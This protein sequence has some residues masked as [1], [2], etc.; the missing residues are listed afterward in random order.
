MIRETSSPRFKVLYEV[1]SEIKSGKDRKD[2]LREVIKIVREELTNLAGLEQDE[3]IFLDETSKDGWKVLKSSILDYQK[4]L[5][6]IETYIKSNDFKKIDEGLN[7]ASKADASLLEIYLEMNKAYQQMKE[8]LESKEKVICLKCGCENH[9]DDK[10]CHKCNQALPKVFKE[11]T[12]YADISGSGVEEAYGEVEEYENIK[13]LRNMIDGVL[14]GKQE[15]AGIVE[16]VEK[17]KK[18]YEGALKQFDAVKKVGKGLFPE[19]LEN[20]NLS[21]EVIYDFIKNFD[22][23]L[24]LSKSQKVEGLLPV[25][26]KIEE[27]AGE[28]GD[29][30]KNFQTISQTLAS[31]G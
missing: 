31:K 14:E 16:Y 4:A 18:M 12:E 17:L 24:S 10:Y 1:I 28:L 2:D 19:I 7:L 13:R 25:L 22:D 23:I 6:V 26:G 8:D 15:I 29:L 5:E 27:L 3:T 21:R 9:K 30:R 20:V 11:V